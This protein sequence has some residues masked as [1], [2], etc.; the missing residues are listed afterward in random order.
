MYGDGKMLP[1]LRSLDF[2]FGGT[3][4]IVVGLTPLVC[5][6][7]VK[8]VRQRGARR[9]RENGNFLTHA[10]LE[11]CGTLSRLESST[12][13]TPRFEREKGTLYCASC[14]SFGVGEQRHP[15]GT[16]FEWKPR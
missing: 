7:T 11:A 1:P 5:G 12:V 9:G 6:Q 3:R 14:G 10:T 4:R 2:G 13:A 16:P 8:G 15:I